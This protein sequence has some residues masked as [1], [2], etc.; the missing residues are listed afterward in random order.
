VSTLHDH[1]GNILSIYRG[2]RR[3]GGLHPEK[4]DPLRTMNLVTKYFSD[5]CTRVTVLL[6]YFDLILIM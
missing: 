1:F 5:C 6:E 4:L 2:G 3:S